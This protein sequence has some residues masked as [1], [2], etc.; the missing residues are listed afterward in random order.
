MTYAQKLTESPNLLNDQDIEA[1]HTAGWDEDAVYEATALISF[2][3]YSGRM[4]AAAGLPMDKVPDGARL[5]EA[6]PDHALTPKLIPLSIT[7]GGQASS[8]VYIPTS[9]DM[10]CTAR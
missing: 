1:L 3:N 10:T 9:G 6:T 2:F 7:Q 5:A 4:E 8:T